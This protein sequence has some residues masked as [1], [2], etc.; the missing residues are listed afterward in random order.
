M[1]RSDAL[2][3][4]QKTLTARRNEL[5]KRIHGELAGLRAAA[6][7]SGDAADAAFDNA[8]EELAS[9]LAELEAKELAQINI[10]LQ[11]IKQGSY[12]VCDGCS[13]KIPV[14]RLSAL[15]YST[16]CIKCQ[17]ESENDSSFLS[18]RGIL[19]W[20][21]VRDYDGDREIR[22]ADLEARLRD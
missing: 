1:A 16:L 5:R 12:G 8:G 7:A 14:A 9:Q 3:T 2:K 6:N 22:F 13:C 21:G 10:A 19:G 15:P 4:L 11:K 17:R 18:D 20:E